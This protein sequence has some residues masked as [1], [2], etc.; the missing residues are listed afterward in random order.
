MSEFNSPR[1]RAVASIAGASASLLLHLLLIT[2]VLWGAASHRVRAQDE[3]GGSKSQVTTDDGAIIAFFIDDA[4]SAANPG[5][6]PRVV[7]S[8][9]PSTRNV[10]TPVAV[11]D[12]PVPRVVALSDKETEE[13]DSSSVEV[14]GAV[15]PGRALMFGRY[16]GQ[17]TARV[18]RAWLRPR[19]QLASGRFEC[20]ARIVQ[21]KDGSVREIELEQCSAD[22]HWQL[23]LVRAIQSASPLPAP[24]NPSVFSRT[25]RVQFTS[26][27]FSPSADPTGFEPEPHTA[28]R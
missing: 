21:E 20:R 22:P 11:P 6:A 1:R 24:P 5:S 23:S 19:T 13:Q 2:P 16:I 18:D 4:D 10:L 7:P 12:I 8:F 25:L 9:M 26:E 17:I 28:M 14:S 15:D 3:G 27:L